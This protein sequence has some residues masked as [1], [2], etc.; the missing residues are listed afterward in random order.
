[1]ANVHR[2]ARMKIPKEIKM[3]NASLNTKLDVYPKI[4][5]LTLMKKNK[6]KERK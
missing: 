3:Y 4:C 6:I 2:L 1:M 5:Y